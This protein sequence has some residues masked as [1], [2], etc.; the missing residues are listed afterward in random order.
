MLASNSAATVASERAWTG[1]FLGLNDCRGFAD[2]NANSKNMKE[3][4]D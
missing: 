2:T 1:C 4:S 3:A